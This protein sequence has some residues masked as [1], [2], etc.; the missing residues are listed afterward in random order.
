M[1]YPIFFGPLKFV[2]SNVPSARNTA[3]RHRIRGIMT[4]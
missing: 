1:V 4:T 3:A 2:V